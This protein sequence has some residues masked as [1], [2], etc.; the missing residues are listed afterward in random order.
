MPVRRCVKSWVAVAAVFVLSGCASLGGPLEHRAAKSELLKYPTHGFL[1]ALIESSTRSGVYA[2]AQAQQGKGLYDKQCAQCHGTLLQGAGQI[3]PLVG[4][5]FLANWAG[6][7][8][9]DLYT[10]TQTTMPTSQPGSLKPDEMAQ[11]LAYILSANRFPAGKQEL[12]ER[13]EKL[14][15][16]H[17][18]RPDQ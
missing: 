5:D 9:A 12:P 10:Q 4:E 14:K 17:I 3:A 2:A 6:R 16:I 8:L 1:S 15:E 13:L 11:L 7:T 18:D